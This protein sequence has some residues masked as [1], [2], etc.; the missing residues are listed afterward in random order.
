MKFLEV[1]SLTESC[2]IAA[3]NAMGLEDPAIK[4]RSSNFYPFFHPPPPPPAMLL[5]LT[6]AFCV[7][8]CSEIES[9]SLTVK[10]Q[11]GKE[12]QT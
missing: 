3:A 1:A 4:G 9:L 11:T 6:C 5:R 2:K 7:S 10:A 12:I 8:T